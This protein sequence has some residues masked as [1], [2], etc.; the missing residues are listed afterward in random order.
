MEKVAQLIA[1]FGFPVVLALGMGYFIYFV[2]KFVTETLKP[3]LGKG[4]KELIRLLDQIRML[5]NDLIRLQSKV[6]TVL[7]YRQ[8]EEILEDAEEK[9]ALKEK[10]KNEKS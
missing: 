5:D 7:E 4:N 3:S 1:E 9:E 8:R 6:N 10:E 2:W